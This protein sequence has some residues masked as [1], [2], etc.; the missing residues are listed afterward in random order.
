MPRLLDL[1][2]STDLWIEDDDCVEQLTFISVAPDG[3]SMRVAAGELSGVSGGAVMKVC[4]KDEEGI[5]I[6]FCE[7]TVVR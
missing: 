5:Y 3:H 4:V 7:V 1:K 2:D 6:T